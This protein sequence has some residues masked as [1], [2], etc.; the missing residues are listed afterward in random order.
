MAELPDETVTEATRLT[1]LAREAVDPDEA[2]AY[3]EH[4]ADLLAEHGFTARVREDDATATLVLHPD[5][6]VEDGTIRPERV[7]DTGRAVEVQVAGPE[8]PDD[9]DTVEEHNRAVARRVRANQGAIHGANA[10][11]FADFMGNHYAKPVEDATPEE[12]AEFL[13]EYFVRNAWPSEDQ[14]EAIERSLEHVQRVGKTIR[15]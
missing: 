12:R 13:A 5:D 4:R 15:R 9:W 6:W 3:R 7:A 14:K 2:A 8:S 10:D 1:K 11:A